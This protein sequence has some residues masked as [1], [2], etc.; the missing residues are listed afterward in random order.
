[1]MKSGHS[2]RFRLNLTNRAIEIFDK[3]MTQTELFRTR[4][5]VQESRNRNNNQDWFRNAGDCDVVVN[6]PP[7]K[8]QEL[9]KNIRNSLN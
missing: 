4:N 3:K 8:D 2:E 5:E 6:I 7:T 9:L 1:M